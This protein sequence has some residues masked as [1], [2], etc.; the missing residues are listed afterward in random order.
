MINFLWFQFGWWALVLTATHGQSGLGLIVVFV[1]LGIH[2]QW[3]S[4]NKKRDLV[5]LVTCASLGISGDFLLIQ[6]GVFTIPPPAPFFPLWL[7]GMWLLFPLTLPH[8]MERFLKN[9]FFIPLLALA[10]GF[11]YYAGTHF[12]ILIT[13]DPVPQNLLI[14]S[15]A[16]WIYLLSFKKLMKRLNINP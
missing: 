11:S 16:W 15:L 9:A 10:A 5:L 2:F 14:A 13:N 6:I 4:K 12:Q 3:V 7:L 1:L 8:S